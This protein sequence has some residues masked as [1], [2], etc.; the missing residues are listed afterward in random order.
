M[1]TLGLGLS[2]VKRDLRSLTTFVAATIAFFGLVLLV[3][4]AWTGWNANSTAV[5]RERMLVENALDQ[6]I[7]RVLNE[8]KSVA[9]WDDAVLNV[10]TGPVNIEW[11]DINF[12]M[13][14][15]ETY[16]HAEIYVLDSQDRAVWSWV[17]GESAAP[18]C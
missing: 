2:G 5:E 1:W 6:G 12:G 7:T 14:L 16:G 11:A 17:D 10:A 18:R 3:V 8:Q 4:V 9:W 13:Y 15:S